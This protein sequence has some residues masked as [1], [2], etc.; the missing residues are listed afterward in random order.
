MSLLRSH[1]PPKKPPKKDSKTCKSALAKEPVEEHT[2]KVIMDDQSTED[3]PSLDDMH[4]SDPKD[5]DNAYI[6]K[7]PTTTTCDIPK[8][9]NNWMDALAETDQ[10]PVDNKLH[11][12]TR[13][14][15]S[16]IKWYCKRIGKEKL[17][18]AD[19]EGPTFM[20]VKGFHENII[21]L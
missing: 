8:A 9:H 14:I 5:N 10:D 13:D 17:N 7:V 19:L 6:S 20:M 1:P 4:V 3:I 18:E 12:K 2:E 15:G 16:F 21:T 11:R